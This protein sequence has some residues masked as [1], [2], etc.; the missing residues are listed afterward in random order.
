MKTANVEIEM[1]SSTCEFQRRFSF[2]QK[3]VQE[4]LHPME[5]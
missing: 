3:A 5:V 4:Y 2:M 1:T